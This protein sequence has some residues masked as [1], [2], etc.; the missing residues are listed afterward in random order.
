MPIASK[1]WWSAEWGCWPIYVTSLPPTST[2]SKNTSY[3]RRSCFARVRSS[4]RVTNNSPQK[5]FCLSLSSR[6]RRLASS[7]TTLRSTTLSTPIPTSTPNLQPINNMAAYTHRQAPTTWEATSL[8]CSLNPARKVRQAH[9]SSATSP[10]TTHCS[11][12][13]EF[14]HKASANSTKTKASASDIDRLIAML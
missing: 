14:T 13:P 9:P 2:I 12:G 7:K 1:D 5:T 10:T 6:C 11:I 8:S 3:A 4:F